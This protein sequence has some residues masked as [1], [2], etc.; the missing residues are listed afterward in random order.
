MTRTTKTPAQRAQEALDVADRRVERCNALYDRA[1][2]DFE[3]ASVDLLSAERRRDYL[4]S[5]PDLP[6]P[7]LEPET[8]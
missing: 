4:A 7:N 1:K 2:T 5:D 6:T 3:Q 8:P